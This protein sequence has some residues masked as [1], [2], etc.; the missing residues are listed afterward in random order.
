[1]TR[2]AKLLVAI[3]F[4]PH[5]ARA[6]DCAIDVAKAFG[7]QI[8]LI[9]AYHLP[10]LVGMPDELVI[11]P[12]FWTGVRDVAARKLA[13]AA[14]KVRAAGVPVETHLVEFPASDAIVE[15]ARRLGADLIVMGTRGLTGLKHALLGSVAERTL[16]LAP[17]AVLTVKDETAS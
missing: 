11:P 16:R 4:S 15:T 6:L 14:E 9:H 8:H 3:D 1:V 12:D 5:S 13:K 2:F 10:P 17:C 7:G